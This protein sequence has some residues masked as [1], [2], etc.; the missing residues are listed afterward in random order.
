MDQTA[1]LLAQQAIRAAISSFETLESFQEDIS[2]PDLPSAKVFSIVGCNL[3][4]SHVPHV[5]S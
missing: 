4:G 5:G 2:I 1:T 3:V